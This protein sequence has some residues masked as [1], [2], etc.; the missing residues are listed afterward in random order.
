MFACNCFGWTRVHRGLF[1]R[2]IQ[3]GAVEH[4]LGKLRQPIGVGAGVWFGAPIVSGLCCLLLLCCCCSCCFDPV[5]CYQLKANGS[6]ISTRIQHARVL[7]R[8][9]S[10]MSRSHPTSVAIPYMRVCSSERVVQA[11][12][13][14]LLIV[15]LDYSTSDRNKIDTNSK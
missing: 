13:R 5:Q 10:R 9:V 14:M 3:I 12:I 2:R 7:K 4:W 11:G 6:L 15:S 8:G 1:P